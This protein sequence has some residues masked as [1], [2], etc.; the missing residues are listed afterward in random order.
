MICQFFTFLLSD[1][2]LPFSCSLDIVGV[3]FEDPVVRVAPETVGTIRVCIAMNVSLDGIHTASAV[4]Q[5]ENV[6]AQGECT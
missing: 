6:T 2:T 3:G 1:A 5:T 4:V